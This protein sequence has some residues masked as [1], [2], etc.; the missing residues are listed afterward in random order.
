MICPKCGRNNEGNYCPYCDEL[1]IDDNT[2]EYNKRR[3][4]YE[5]S[6]QRDEDPT[7]EETVPKSRF[8][9]KHA[10]IILSVI[11]AAL[12][13]ALLTTHL[14]KV[15]SGKVY[16]ESGGAVNELSG[17][18]GLSPLPGRIYSYGGKDIYAN[19]TVPDGVSSEAGSGLKGYSASSKGEYFAL[20]AY[21]E[22]NTEEPYSLYVWDKNGS[23]SKVLSQKNAIE[24]KDVTDRGEV[25]YTSSS[26]LNDQW[27]MGDTSL[28]ICKV[29]GS[30]GGALDCMTEKVSDRIDRFFIYENIRCLVCLD[31]DGVLFSCPGFNGAD[32]KVVAEGVSRV[33]GETGDEDNYF[34]EAAPTVNAYTNAD[35]LAFYKD[36]IWEMYDTEGRIGLTLGAAGENASF[37]YDDNDRVLF[38]AEDQGLS[39]CVVTES[40]LKPWEK[41]SDTVGN[42]VWIPEKST[43]VY[44]TGEGNVKRAGSNEDITVFEGAEKNSLMRVQNSGG[45]LFRAA[46]GVYTVRDVKEQP[47]L[48]KGDIQGDIHRCAEYKGAVYIYAGDKLYSADKAGDVAECG[49]CEGLYIV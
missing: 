3:K 7:E 42:M 24:V 23:Y 34:S 6:L 31:K 36:G 11:A 45:Y 49:N 39:R 43:L 25:I 20:V 47:V 10:I 22:N 9:V 16:A 12:I 40:G 18:G 5:H 14:P 17:E 26:V 41:L 1:Q 30:S 44:E 37:V 46:D 21:E 29:K 15:Y 13:V 48:L 28:H 19:V 35:L 38:K 33:L 27:Y 32:R 4:A 8:K 2:D